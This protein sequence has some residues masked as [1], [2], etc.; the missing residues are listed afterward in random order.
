TKVS[1]EV[2][3]IIHQTARRDEIAKRV[4]RGQAVARSERENKITIFLGSCI[5]GR[6]QATV[7]SAGKS[8]DGPFDVIAIGYWKRDYLHAN[9]R[10]YHLC[11]RQKIAV[12]ERILV[13][14]KCDT[15]KKRRNL[16]EHSKPL[17]HNAVFVE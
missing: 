14:N 13:T 10:S 12:R 4:D 15:R 11:G 1:H 16:L 8:L 5:V 9:G 2:C 6:E 3:S 17:S 7:G